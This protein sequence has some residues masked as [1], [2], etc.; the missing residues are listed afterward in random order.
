MVFIGLVDN[1]FNIE[2]KKYF[3]EQFYQDY[4]IFKKRKIEFLSILICFHLKVSNQKLGFIH[5]L[6]NNSAE[7]TLHFLHQ[8]NN[9]FLEI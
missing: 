3:W 1:M 7:T 5:I 8:K 4:T 9:I 2:F 6:P